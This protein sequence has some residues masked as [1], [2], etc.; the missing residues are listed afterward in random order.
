MGPCPCTEKYLKKPALLVLEDGSAFHGISI[1]ADGTSTGEVVFNTSMTGYQEI[2]TDPSYA[3]Q[4]VTL[5]YPHI[6]NVG[7]NQEDIESRRV[8]CSG[9]VV[10][11]VPHQHSNWRAGQ[12]LPDYLT[13]N[14]VVAIAGIDTRRL[15]RLIRTKGA[16]RACLQAGPDCDF[17]TALAAARAFPGLKGMDLARVVTASSRYAW[18]GGEWSLES[19]YIQ[20]FDFRFDVV[21][22]DFGVKHNILRCWNSGAAG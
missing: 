4:L 9:L 13:E 22:Y 5:T 1:G 10:K 2:L 18:S 15:T 7:T 11:N 8:F 12:S 19:G 3:Q 17:D 6:G 20:A 21:A 16:Q 14:N